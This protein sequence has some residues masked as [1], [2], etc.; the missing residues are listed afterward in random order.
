MRGSQQFGAPVAVRGRLGAAVVGAAIA[1]PA[2]APGGAHAAIRHPAA[3]PP[4]HASAPAPPR[5]RGPG[6]VIFGHK[7][8]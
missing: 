1:L 3:A 7:L 5:G 4:K 8:G 2:L 6:R